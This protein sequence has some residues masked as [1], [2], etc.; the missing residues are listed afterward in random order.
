MLNPTTGAQMV[1]YLEKNKR[2]YAELKY[3]GFSFLDDTEDVSYEHYYNEATM[4]KESHQPEVEVEFLKVLVNGGDVNPVER[5]TE[6]TEYKIYGC[7]FR[8]YDEKKGKTGGPGGVLAMQRQ[9]LGK[10]FKDVPI[11]YLFYTNKVNYSPQIMEEVKK[12]SGKVKS[13][14]QGAY[15]IQTHKKITE[16]IRNGVIPVLVCHDI[17]T[18]YGAYL[19]GVKY[20]VIYHQQ[21]SIKN[22]MEAVGVEPTEFESAFLDKVERRV[23]ENAEQVYFPSK[24]AESVLKS[25]S[26]IVANSDKIRFSE[27][28]LYNTIKNL[29]KKYNDYDLLTEL[30]IPLVDKDNVEVFFSCGDYNYDKGMERIPDFLNLYTQNTK[31][32]VLWIAIGSSGNS[33]IYEELVSKK[34]LWNF[35]A[36]LLGERVDHEKL[37]LIANY[38]DYYLMMH[39]NAIFDLAI[40]EAMRAEKPLIL[41]P[42]GGNVEFNVCD[43]VIF[44]DEEC[45][46]DT[47]RKIQ[48][49]DYTEWCDKNKN[50]FENYFSNEKFTEEYKV[51]IDKLL[52]SDG[53]KCRMN[54]DINKVTMLPWK[55]KFKGRKAIICGSGSSLDSYEKDKEAIHI[56][57]N[58]ALFY[59]KIKFDFCFM[60]DYPQNQP[61]TIDDYNGYPCT[62]MYGIIT[63]KRTKKIG[64]YR[65]KIAAMLL[66]R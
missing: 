53:F 32:K 42:V 8:E 60:Q 43:N 52:R 25:T 58:R 28:A 2:S 15:F 59:E 26:L 18:A 14:I 48:E 44:V 21:G 47:I 65:E 37:L 55:N 38:C 34:H 54:S 51:A 39:R 23:F 36:V 22:E 63:N 49:I 61:Y 45:M 41:S 24:G 20:I 33:G 19:L 3:Y 9:L 46:N 62:K 10:T 31:K 12:V 4:A 7:T 35:E 17:G 56:A 66:E 29:T 5:Y 13:I 6:K 30:G 16:D 64:L 40:L 27:T 11:E 50:A 1:F 57:L